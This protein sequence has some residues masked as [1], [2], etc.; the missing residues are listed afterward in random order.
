MGPLAPIHSSSCND[1]IIYTHLALLLF[2]GGREFFCACFKNFL[3]C[4]I[5]CFQ[6]Y[7]E[8]ILLKYKLFIFK[9]ICRKYYAEKGKYAVLRITGSLSFSSKEFPLFLLL[10]QKVSMSLLSE[11]LSSWEV[12]KWINKFIHRNADFYQF[13]IFPPFYRFIE[14]FIDLFIVYRF[15]EINI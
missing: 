11:Q 8:L 9:L 6:L 5:L 2:V 4:C 1:V 15:I 14:I 12:K 10:G 3:Y 7:Y 13:I